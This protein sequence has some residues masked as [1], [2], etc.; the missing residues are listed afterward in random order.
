[1][2]NFASGYR[3]FGDN[4]DIFVVQDFTFDMDKV[5]GFISETRAKGGVSQVGQPLKSQPS[6][7]YACSKIYLRMFKAPFI[8]GRNL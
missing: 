6:I 7:S 1:M 4:N 8:K 5:K 3:D 2:N